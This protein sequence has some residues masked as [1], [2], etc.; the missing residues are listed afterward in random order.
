[1]VTPPPDSS[2]STRQAA[3]RFLVVGGTNTLMTTAI[4]IGLSYVMP[5]WL[6]YTISFAL[7]L[8]YSTIFAAR[9]I[10]ARHGSPRRAA[11]YALCYLAI[12]GV[13]LAVIAGVRALGWP[14]Y[15]NALSIFITAPLGFVAGRIV[16]HQ[17]EESNHG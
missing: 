4:L 13:G 3:W 14:T 2:R 1:M 6:A 16:F 8:A 12:F 7:G 11:L 15:T 9:W 10:F 17:R 5:G